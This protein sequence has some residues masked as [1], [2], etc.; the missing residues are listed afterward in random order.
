MPKVSLTKIKRL[1]L[2]RNT[3]GDKNQPMTK[4]KKLGQIEKIE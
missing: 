4:S 1:K 3:A 2:I